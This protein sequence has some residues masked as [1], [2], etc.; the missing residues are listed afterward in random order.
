[1]RI[2]STVIM[3]QFYPFRVDWLIDWYGRIHVC[4]LFYHSDF[5]NLVIIIIGNQSG[6]T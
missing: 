2:E 6:K 3:R 1:M 5:F 4:E